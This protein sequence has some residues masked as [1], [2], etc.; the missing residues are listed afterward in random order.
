MS[1]SKEHQ[2]DSILCA[3]A[4]QHKGGVPEVIS[5]LLKRAI[6]NCENFI[7]VQFVEFQLLETVAAFLARKTDFFVGGKDGEWQTVRMILIKIMIEVM[8][9]QKK[10]FFFQKLTLNFTISMSNKC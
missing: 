4:E 10:N 8:S 3:L 5:I 2:F 9:N 1:D 6:A 7:K